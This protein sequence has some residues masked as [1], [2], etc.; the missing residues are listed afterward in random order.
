MS[1]QI[2]WKVQIHSK[3]LTSQTINAL[4]TTEIQHAIFCAIQKELLF[5][6]REAGIDSEDVA[7]FLAVYGPETLHLR[8]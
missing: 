8:D 2:N 6:L 1:T 5:Q 4:C 3:A 7:P